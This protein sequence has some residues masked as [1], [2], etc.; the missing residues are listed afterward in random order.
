MSGW[1]EL[2]ADLPESHT[3][4]GGDAVTITFPDGLRWRV[5][6]RA[7]LRMVWDYGWA[8]VWEGWWR[9]DTTVAVTV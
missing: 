1:A 2:N 4:S 5:P 8:V 9:C 7:K 6:W 3:S